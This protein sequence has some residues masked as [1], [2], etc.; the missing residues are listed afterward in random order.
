MSR[1]LLNSLL[2]PTDPGGGGST[3]PSVYVLFTSLVAIDGCGATTISTML[4]MDP[5]DLSTMGEGWLTLP[6]EKVDLV[7][8]TSVSGTETKTRTIRTTSWGSK[9]Y[10]GQTTG[11]F[12][13]KHL[14]CPPENVMVR[15]SILVNKMD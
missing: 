6:D 8:S 14:P 3:S 9:S 10:R 4:P 2:V 7:Y 13:L 5:T 12:D 1:C 11:L 15:L